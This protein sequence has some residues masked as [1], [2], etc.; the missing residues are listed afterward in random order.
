MNLE[1]FSSVLETREGCSFVCGLHLGAAF[2]VL[3]GPVG[4]EF[5]LYGAAETTKSLLQLNASKLLNPEI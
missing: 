4:M 2:W 3:A 5:T 1:G